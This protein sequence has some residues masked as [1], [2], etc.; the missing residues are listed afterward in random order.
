MKI[1]FFCPRAPYPPD[2]GDRI[3]SFNILKYL[4]KNHEIYLFC[5]IEDEKER[6]NIAHLENLVKKVYYQKITPFLKKTYSLSG[7]FFR[8]PISVKYFYSLKHQKAFNKLIN[9][10]KIDV[11]FSF[12]SS[13]AEYLFRAQ[14][15]NSKTTKIKKIIDL[16]DVDSEKWLEYSQKK[17]WPKAF[18]KGIQIKII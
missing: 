17:R 13:V 7:L 6:S 8:Q 11:F 14:I 16:V 12:C 2:R 18:S 15:P 10:E 4:S 3:R 5:N 1:A 9:E